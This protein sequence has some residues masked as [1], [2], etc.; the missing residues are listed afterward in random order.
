MQTILKE[1]C[2]AILDKTKLER[3]EYDVTN[4]GWFKQL[5]T[6]SEEK[7]IS[8]IINNY[9]KEI[10]GPDFDKYYEVVYRDNY[11]DNYNLNWHLDDRILQKHPY[12][13]SD[14]LQ[15]INIKNG[16]EYGLWNRRTDKKILKRTIII[17][18]SSINKDFTGG[19]FEFL[20]RIIKPDIGLM[21]SF[22]NYDLHR[23]Q[24]LK[25]GHRKAVVIKIYRD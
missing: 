19:E 21:I 11:N 24:K 12:G 4:E 5:Q 22:N 17:Y 20:D 7:N 2:A 23:V 1:Y 14:G 3:E 8:N 18:L 13:T 6:S 9:K 10:L 25:E 16:Y 15:I